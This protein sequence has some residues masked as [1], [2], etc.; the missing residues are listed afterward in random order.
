MGEKKSSIHPNKI[1]STR[2]SLKEAVIKPEITASL[3]KRSKGEALFTYKEREQQTGQKK[4]SINR[5]I[6]PAR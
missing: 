6:G 3:L 2:S 4:S 1:N 5:Q